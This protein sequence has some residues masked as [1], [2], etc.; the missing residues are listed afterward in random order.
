MSLMNERIS[1]KVPEGLFLI[2]GS[3]SEVGYPSSRI[4]RGL[5]L[6][7]GNQD[8]SEEGLGFG[9]PVLKFNQ[10]TFFPGFL[11][12]RIEREGNYTVIKATYHMNLV[13]RMTRRGRRISKRIVY[14]VREFFSSLHRNHPRLRR[15]LSSVSETLR[16]TLSLDD[17]FETV[18][19]AGEVQAI[20]AVDGSTIHVD[21]K[22]EKGCGCKEVIVLNEQG[23]NSFDAYCDSDGLFLQ[24]DAIGTWDEVFAKEAHF[25]D[26]QHRL[27]FMIQRVDW[28]KLF[29]GREVS[30]RRLAWA[31]FAYVLPP[32]TESFAYTIHLDR[33]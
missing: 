28:A 18:P 9:V 4:Q 6:S 14:R 24:G 15:W 25:L 26:L 21:L 20:Y 19:S 33:I 5:I 8:L 22:V 3:H 27:T 32:I 11:R 16:H 12:S 17:V 10:E 7:Y 29:R 1:L 13:A 31:G 2:M 23:A 30:P